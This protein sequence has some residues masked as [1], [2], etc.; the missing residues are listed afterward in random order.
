M[1]HCRSPTNP[2]VSSR[3]LRSPGFE[4]CLVR[5]LTAFIRKRSLVLQDVTLRATS[6]QTLQLQDLNCDPLPGPPVPSLRL[7]LQA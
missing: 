5:F 4:G 3:T 6:V 1:E 2:P 7:S